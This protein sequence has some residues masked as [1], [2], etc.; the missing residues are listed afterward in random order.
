MVVFCFVVVVASACS[1]T[2]SP[3]TSP[4]GQGPNTSVVVEYV[5]NA[6]TQLGYLDQ[7]NGKFD[8]A[9]IEG[10]RSF[11][12]ANHLPVTGELD[13]KTAL[14]LSQKSPATKRYAVLALQTELTELGTS[15]A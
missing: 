14:A 6:L 12:K 5:Q 4:S 9:T 3:P 13:A 15:P 11:Q 2:T 8:R 10:L 1:S 7:V